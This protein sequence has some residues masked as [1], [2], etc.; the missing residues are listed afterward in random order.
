MRITQAETY[1]MFLSNLETLN[2]SYNKASNQVTTGKR[3][4][5]LS[6]SPGD[7]AELIFMTDKAAD[8][9]Q[10]QSTGNSVSYYL[11][12]ADTALTQAIN[13]V[14]S[15]TTVTNNAGS[16]SL[17]ND[18]RAAIATQLRSKRD[19][20]LSLA[21]SQAN[22]RYLFAGSNVTSVPYTIQGDTVT[23]HGDSNVATVQVDDGIEVASGVS[24]SEAF[25]SVFSWI[26]SMVTAL[27]ANDL[28]AIGSALTQLSSGF[29]QLGLARNKL[30]VGIT[31]LQSVQA[32]LST[33]E[34]N[35]QVQRGKLEDADMAEATVQLSQ[36]Q[37]ALQTA[38]T[39]GGS[40][41]QQRNLFD[42]LG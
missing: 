34:A 39:A 16:N 19:E 2:E 42:I 8:I 9:D 32:R 38:V 26:Q 41:L 13:L 17:S 29:T 37:T 21:N 6:D 36:T 22:G 40:I 18:Q 12:V 27:D 24:G 10:Y 28:S 15:F 25:D 3:L 14:S 4:N 30:D 20:I 1:R 7:S 23:Y 11:G 35:L 33:E 31:T 5:H